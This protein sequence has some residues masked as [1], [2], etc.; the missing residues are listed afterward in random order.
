MIVVIN[1]NRSVPSYFIWLKYLSWFN[2]AN[3]LLQ[4][5]QW[6]GLTGISCPFVNSTTSRCLLSGQDV[7]DYSKMDSSNYGIDFGALVI[8]FGG[9]IILTF[10]VLLAKSYRR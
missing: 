9:W 7:L 5:N 1:K 8:L 10:L 3:E 2:Y 4:L 6:S